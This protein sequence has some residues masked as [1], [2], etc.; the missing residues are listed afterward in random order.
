MCDN[1]HHIQYIHSDFVSI[2]ND[3]LSFTPRY[4]KKGTTTTD[5]ATKQIYKN[6]NNMSALLAEIEYPAGS[7]VYKAFRVT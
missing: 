1:H 4:E 6:N 3:D 5:V 2:K 7:P